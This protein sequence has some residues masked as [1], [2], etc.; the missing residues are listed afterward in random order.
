MRFFNP[1]GTAVEMCG[2]GARCVARLAADIGVA[3]KK[4]SFETIAGILK[5]SVTDTAVV[6]EMTPPEDWTL[7]RD[8]EIDGTTYACPS[9]N[10]GVPHVVVTVD[11]LDG[12]DVQKQGSAIRYHDA[13][14]PAGTNANFVKVMEGNTLAVRTYERGVEG[15]TLA[16]GTGMVASALISALLGAVSPPVVMKPAS[17]DT[18][19]V[20]FDLSEDRASNVTLSGP[21]EYVF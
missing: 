5:A 6:L 13:F 14:A 8:L 19:S 15:E 17:G 3:G 9:V 21:S 20:D 7:G 18:L 10:T 12:L 11:D 4:M 2:N 16:C 1:D